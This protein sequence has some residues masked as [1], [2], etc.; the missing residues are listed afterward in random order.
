MPQIQAHQT[1]MYQ[2]LLTSKLQCQL[3]SP[4]AKLPVR[5]HE[6]DAG[7]DIFAS[8]TVYLAPGEYKVVNTDLAVNVPYG[9]AIQVRGRSGLAFKNLVFCAHNGTVDHGYIG[10]IKVMMHNA[11]SQPFLIEQGTRFAQLV[12]QAVELWGV[13]AVER[14]SGLEDQSSLTDTARG[15]SGF[16]STGV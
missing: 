14:F 2:S 16:G 12:I 11:S 3:L 1:F 7:L 8:E 15:T 4:A 13:E 10:P 6:G 9:Y 5:A